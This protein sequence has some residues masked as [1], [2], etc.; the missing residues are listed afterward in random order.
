M[1]DEGIAY[2]LWGDAEDVLGRTLRWN[3]ETWY[4]RGV[5]EGTSGLAVFPAE[6]TNETPFSGLWLD[7]SADSSG[8]LGAE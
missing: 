3:E 5:M 8:S 7:L 2:F 6:E 1:I 4:V